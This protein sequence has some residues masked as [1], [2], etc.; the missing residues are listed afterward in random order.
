MQ[1]KTLGRRRGQMLMILALAFVPL[2][3]VMGLALDLGFKFALEREVQAAM[4]GASLAGSRALAQ[5]YQYK[6]LKCQSNPTTPGCVGLVA[7][8]DQL[9]RTE[10]VNAATA[11]VQPY[12]VMPAN[13]TGIAGNL[14]WPA[15]TGDSIVAYYLITDG[16]NPPTITQG[17]QVGSTNSDP[18]A[19][20]AGIRVEATLG[21]DTLFTQ[22]LGDC[23][24][25]TY[26]RAA[27]RAML[28]DGAGGAA[29]PFMIC[30]RQATDAPTDDKKYRYGAYKLPTGQLPDQILIDAQGNL[31]QTL[32]DGPALYLLDSPQLENN[33]GGSPG[34]KGRADLSKTCDRAPYGSAFVPCNQ[35]INTGSATGQVVPALVDGGCTSFQP[36]SPCLGVVGVTDNCALDGGKACRVR[37]YALFDVAAY[38]NSA[39]SGCQGGGPSGGNCWSAKLRGGP[40]LC[41]RCPSS[42]GGSGGPFSPTG[43]LLITYALVPDDPNG[44]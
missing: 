30:G 42:G 16:K 3:G 34:W 4:D 10:I 40:A 39:T 1:T 28:Q 24:T 36:T 20:A 38:Q 21:R 37:V 33:C 27:A 43:T 7:W 35:A 13:P 9:I 14:S 12:P 22:V 2:M 19:N 18:P 6:G 26:A 29:V 41:S 8:T 23:C 31:D 25:R 5:W 11:N 44:P 17:V 15:G 32:V